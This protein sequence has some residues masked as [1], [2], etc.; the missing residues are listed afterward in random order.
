VGQVSAL[1][2]P[3][4]LNEKHQLGDFSCGEVSLD[5]WLKQRAAKNEEMR[6]SRTYV[7]CDGSKVIAYYCLAVGSV[8]HQ[9]AP[10]KVKRNMPD[11]VPV[12]ILGRLAIDQKWQGKGIGR[13]LLRDAVLRTLQA[14]EFAGIRAML[15]H[16]LNDS[17]RS[18]YLSNGFHQS[19][20]DPM[21][22]IVTLDEIERIVKS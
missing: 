17:A 19:P 5:L 14:A 2:A 10:S 4:K 11:H 8:E 16:A 3:E 1:K 22:L 7:V 9:R 12:M 20:V 15:V 18:F 21:T 13:A 6:A